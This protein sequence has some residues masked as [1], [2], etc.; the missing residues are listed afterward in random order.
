VLYTASQIALLVYFAIWE[1][2]RAA[3][4]ERRALEEAEHVTLQSIRAIAAVL[5]SV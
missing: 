1:M 4:Q 5:S 3:A 2:N